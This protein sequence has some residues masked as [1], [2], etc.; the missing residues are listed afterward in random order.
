LAPCVTASPAWLT[1]STK[2]T[3]PNPDSEVVG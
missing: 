2:V 1:P 3:D